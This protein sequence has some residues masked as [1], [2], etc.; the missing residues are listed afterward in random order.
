M[1]FLGLL[2]GSFSKYMPLLIVDRFTVLSDLPVTLT[3]LLLETS[4]G[5][6]A[7]SVVLYLWAS[8][9]R[10]HDWVTRANDDSQPA[11]KSHQSID[12]SEEEMAL[13]L[14]KVMHHTCVLLKDYLPLEK[15][16]RLA[17]MVFP[18]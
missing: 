12:K 14:L 16:L 5:E 9:E 10:I 17:N 1:Q 2:C 7:E 11:A 4:W 3:S 18:L 13:F 15:Q 8:M 6:V